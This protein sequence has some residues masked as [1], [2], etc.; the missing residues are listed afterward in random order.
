MKKFI[1]LSIIFACGIFAS[2]VKDNTTAPDSTQPEDKTLTERLTTTTVMQVPVQSGKITVVTYGGDTLCVATKATS[3]MVPKTT[4]LSKADEEIVVTYIGESDSN[5]AALLAGGDK[6]GIWQTLAFEDSRNADHDY[7]DLVLHVRY[8]RSSKANDERF[9]IG[10]QP[11]AYG[12]TKVMKLGCQIRYKGQVVLEETILSENAGV[13]FFTDVTERTFINTYTVNYQSPLFT[14]V[15]SFDARGIALG[16][17][18]VIWCIKVDGEDEKSGQVTLY[19]VND[20]YKFMD[21]TKRPYGIIITKASKTLGDLDTDSTP[22][23][24]SYPKEQVNISD[25]YPGFDA[26]IT[27]AAQSFDTEK[28]DKDK[29]FDIT[30]K[31]LGKHKMMLYEIQGKGH[32]EPDNGSYKDC[33]TH[34]TL[35][36]Y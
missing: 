31:F 21:A 6:S 5:Y 29:I 7:N 22:A 28:Y 13:D 18:Q 17:I 25:C 1:F 32:E 24:F 15:F 16:D 30:Q 27:G 12:A 20:Q 9:Y 10:I 26:W 14:K 19:A 8:Q 23:W 2:C 3:I 4:A 34:Y 35:P 36:N 11:I 33:T